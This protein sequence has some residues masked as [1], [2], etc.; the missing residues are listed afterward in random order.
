MT[1]FRSAIILA[2]AWPSRPM[3][4]FALVPRPRWSGRRRRPPAATFIS[5]L[6][7]DL[8]LAAC[9]R[10]CGPAARPAPAPSETSRPTFRRASR[11]L[12]EG[13]IFS[14]VKK[15]MRADHPAAEHHREADAR[16]QPASLGDRGP[17]AALHLADVGHE[18]QVARLPGL[19]VEPLSLAEPRVREI[20]RNSSATDPGVGAPVQRLVGRVDLPV[21]AVGPAERLADR[22]QAPR[23]RPP[24]C[25]RPSPA[26][27]AIG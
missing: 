18:H 11:R 26:P 16:V 21:R 2:M 9:P 7:S 14:S 15:S 4:S 19:A 17:R 25:C 3:S 27:S 8:Q 12:A 20:R 22:G 6:T 23:R 5:S 1:C 13:L 24:P 10:R